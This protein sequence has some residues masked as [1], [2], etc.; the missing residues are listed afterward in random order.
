MGMES[1]LGPGGSWHDDTDDGED[2]D[3]DEDEDE[4]EAEMDY[5]NGFLFEEFDLDDESLTGY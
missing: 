4:E 2:E 1:N 5:D 3:R